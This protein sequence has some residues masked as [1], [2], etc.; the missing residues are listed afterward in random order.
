M[1]ESSNPVYRTLFVCRGNICRS[2]YAAV[3]AQSQGVPGVEF[4]S[5][6]I[7]AVVGGRISA[8]MADE[9]RRRG[10][11]GAHVARQLTREIADDSDLILTM[12]ASHKQWI[13]E[14]W[15]DLGHKIFVIGQAARELACAPRGMPLGEVAPYL[16]GRRTV[17]PGDDVADPYGRGPQAAKAA[18][19]TIDAFLAPI[20]AALAAAP[21]TR[22]P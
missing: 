11:H 22:R 10:P 20:L 17:R 13:L 9:L 4:A 6:G 7:Q 19:L 14:D 12:G 8:T 3:R 16:W 15:P 21:A 1:G 2:P 18:A 5:A